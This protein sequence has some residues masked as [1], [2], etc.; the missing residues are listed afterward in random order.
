[1]LDH[2]ARYPSGDQRKVTGLGQ[3]GSSR[4]PKNQGWN[5]P[6]KGHRD[7]SSSNSTLQKGKER[8][9]PASPDRLKAKGGLGRDR[10]DGCFLNGIG[11]LIVWWGRGFARRFPRLTSGGWLSR[12]RSEGIGSG[13]LWGGDWSNDSRSF[14]EDVHSAGWGLFPWRLWKLFLG[15]GAA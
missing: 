11:V 9:K 2:R 15:G 5:L 7:R 3:N 6:L 12:W 4:I 1:M 13:Y 14:R 10:L 8:W